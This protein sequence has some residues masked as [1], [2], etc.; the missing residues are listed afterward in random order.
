MIPQQLKAQIEALPEVAVPR[1][2]IAVAQLNHL[3]EYKRSRQTRAIS[4]V[5]TRDQMVVYASTPEGVEVLTKIMEE[6]Q[7]RFGGYSRQT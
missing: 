7:S 6:F 1:L 5:R 3:L 4:A 2:A